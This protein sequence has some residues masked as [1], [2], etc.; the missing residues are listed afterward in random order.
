MIHKETDFVVAIIEEV[1]GK[2]NRVIPPSLDDEVKNV[3]DLC[4]NKKMKWKNIAAVIG[5]KEKTLYRWRVRTNYT[6]PRKTDI[7]DAALDEEIAKFTF[8]HPDTGLK[9]LKGYLETCEE[10]VFVTRSRLIDSISRVDPE[11]RERRKRTAAIQRRVYN[12]KGPHH[13]WHID[14][15]H[16]MIDYHFVIH[17]G[18]DGFSRAIT[19]V[20]CSDNNRA[21][22]VLR[23][24]KAAVSEF[25]CPSRLRCDKGGEN[26]DVALYMIEMRGLNRN[27]VILGRSVHNQRIERFWRDLRKD[28]TNLYKT[29]FLFLEKSHHFD[30]DDPFVIFC[31]HYL[32]LD[33]I[34]KDLKRYQNIWNNHALSTEHNLSPH[35]LLLLHDV[36]SASIE[37]PP[38]Q[39]DENEYGIEDDDDGNGGGDDGNDENG[40][41]LEP[42]PCPLT[43]EECDILIE[44]VPVVALEDSSSVFLEKVM[45]CRNIISHLVSLR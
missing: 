26:M 11:G 4:R 8:D 32:F 25:G 2:N 45:Y 10:P 20:H 37:V 19:F 12:V 16:K 1:G 44:L 35:E 42:L 43:K 36:N 22:T 18:I 15:W 39:V 14:G 23:H 33:R 28:V 5:I 40:V 21:A 17:A 7:T 13:L 24:F 3:L 6:D 29:F 30:F 34:N 9:I 41:P 27:S 38:E 31:I